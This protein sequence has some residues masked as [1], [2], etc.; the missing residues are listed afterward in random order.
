MKIKIN[1]EYL[2]ILH[3]IDKNPDVSQRG[4]AKSTNLSLGK[5]NYCIKALI[6]IGFVKLQNFSNSKNKSGYLY[7][8][9]PKGVKEKT[10]ITKNFLK[11]KQSEYENLCKYFNQES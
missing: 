5:V 11:R 8:L 1:E 9:T 6:E 4:I 2:K 3:I 7:I 10:I